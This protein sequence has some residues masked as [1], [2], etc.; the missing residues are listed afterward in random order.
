MLSS[1]QSTKK[2]IPKMSQSEDVRKPLETRYYHGDITV[3]SLVALLD[4]IVSA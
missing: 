2:H 4:K 3:A 1:T